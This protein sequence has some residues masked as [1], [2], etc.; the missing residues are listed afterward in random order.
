MKQEQIPKSE[1][2]Q[3]A[4]RAFFTSTSS[5]LGFLAASSLLQHDGFARDSADELKSTSQ[6]SNSASAPHFEPKAK[7]CIFVLP[8]GA[9]SQIDLFD[10]KP[11]L[12]ELDKQPLPKELLDKVRFAFIQK[13]SAVLMGCGRKF[14]KHGESG[15]E[16]SE[17]LPHLATCADDLCL[18]RS[19]HTDSFNHHPAQLMLNS[20]VPR[21][22]RPSMGSWITYGLGSESQNLPAYVVLTAGRGGSGGVS[23]WTSGFLPSSY[24]GV[25][26]RNQGD[27]ILNL[28]N[29]IGIDQEL[30]RESL[31]ALSEL[32][33]L[34]FE[35][36]RDGEIQSRIKSYELA[37]KMQMGAP[38]L[39]DLSQ[40]SE[41]TLQEYGVNRKEPE[42]Y[43]FR[44]GGP[45]V[46]RQFATNC[47]LARRMIERGV[48]FV[49]LIHASWDHHSNIDPELA[50]NAGMADQPLAAL[51]KDLKR[52]GLLDTTLV[53]FAGEFGRTPLGENR[54]GREGQPLGRDHH[55]Y[56]FSVWMSGGGFKG[57]LTYGTTDEI[58]W[59]PIENPVHIHDFHATILHQFGLN[60]L[61]LNYRY[62]GLNVRLTDQ[63]GKVVQDLL[64]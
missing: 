29:P 20:G 32:N 10:P 8:E 12:M 38:E 57:G 42:R 33:Q 21:F 24:E 1:V 30:Q 9:P 55:P 64:S 25:L 15:M 46:Y 36:S 48:R 19:M 49:T 4:R 13:E 40:E 58:G 3:L 27:P 5:G 37:F 17:L 45:N 18:V 52:R 62:A 50:Y 26:F 41:Q 14:G 47:L 11:K 39:L 53:V 16:L 43:D 56:A 63:G 31:N 54:K 44:G 6:Q 51:L 7:Q 34:R 23:N 59:A 61:D 35:T 22:G 28:S 2:E 60:H